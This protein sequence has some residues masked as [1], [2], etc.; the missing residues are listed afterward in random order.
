MRNGRVWLGAVANGKT[1][2]LRV[3]ALIIA[4]LHPRALVG[5]C[6]YNKVTLAPFEVL[7]ADL[8]RAQFPSV[9][10][11]DL[12]DGGRRFIVFFAD[13]VEHLYY[14]RD[15][16][17]LHQVRRLWSRFTAF[18]CSHVIFSAFAAD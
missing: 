13:E 5:Y 10:L 17:A 11:T 14:R 7:R 15:H 16:N 4:L 12:L 18:R 9:D 2:L 8:S 6:E 3:C 1:Q